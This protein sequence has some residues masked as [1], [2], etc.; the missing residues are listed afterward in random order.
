MR[1]EGV[2]ARLPLRPVA[3]VVDADDAERSGNA[4][5]AGI[6]ALPWMMVERVASMPSRLTAVSS[7]GPRSPFSSGPWQSWQFCS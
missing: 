6:V 7:A 5:N 3:Q 2:A 1:E 4:E